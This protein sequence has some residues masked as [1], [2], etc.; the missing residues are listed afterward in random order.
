MGRPGLLG[1]SQPPS[2]PAQAAPVDR[3]G[4]L[5]ALAELKAQGLLTDEEFTAET[6]RVPAS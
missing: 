4:Q 6:A 2:A 5:T 1:A 3:V